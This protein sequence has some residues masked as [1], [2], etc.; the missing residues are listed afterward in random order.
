MNKRILIVTLLVISVWCSTAIATPIASSIADYSDTQE[1]GGWS[2]G[3]FNQGIDSSTL[4]STS[5]FV[6]LDVFDAT[7]NSWRASNGLVGANNNDF[8]SLNSML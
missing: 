3:F 8:L 7:A 5:S 1:Q 4:Y 2:Y 6:Q